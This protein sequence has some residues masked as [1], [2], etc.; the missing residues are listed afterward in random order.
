MKV[1]FIAYYFEPFKGVGAKRV[2]YW[3][4]NIAK[5]T[6]DEILVTVVTATPPDVTTEQDFAEIVYVEDRQDSIYKSFFKHDRGVTWFND[7]RKYFNSIDQDFNFDV[8]LLTG[9]P[10]LHFGIGNFLKKR[11]GCKIILDFRDPFAINPLFSKQYFLKVFIKKCLE[12][13]YISKADYIITVNKYCADLL[14]E[15]DSTKVAIIDNGFDEKLV[16]K[17]LKNN[18]TKD[19]SKINIVYAGKLSQGREIGV[20]LNF[21]EKN[22]NILFHYIGNDYDLIAGRANTI[23]YGAKS[24]E[25]TL[26]IISGCEIGLVLTGGNNFESTTKIFDYIGLEKKVLVISDQ[27]I[28]SG[29]IKDILSKY[30]KHMFCLN[31]MEDLSRIIMEIPKKEDHYTLDT[32]QFS[33][34]RSLTKL[35]KTLNSLN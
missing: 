10:F 6:N 12:K 29:S 27:V 1:L 7:L 25:E 33:R 30:P 19:N 35:I 3:A 13:I 24:Y 18:T 31:N 4:K 23:I 21:I 5:E 8:V 14:S 15:N 34:S 32:F 11:H 2:S 17:A 9:G 26:M 22:P 28:N 20:F 16:G